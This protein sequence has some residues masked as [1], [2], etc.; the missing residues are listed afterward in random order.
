MNIFTRANQVTDEMVKGGIV[1]EGQEKLLLDRVTGLLKCN[2][3]FTDEGLTRM[4]AQDTLFDL[5]AA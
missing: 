2:P 1:K 3:N 4:L 5:W